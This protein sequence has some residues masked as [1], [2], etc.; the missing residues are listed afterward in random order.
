MAIVGCTACCGCCCFA[1]NP[2]TSTKAAG[3]HATVQPAQRPD[4]E[5]YGA[6]EPLPNYKSSSGL[7]EVEPVTGPDE[8]PPSYPEAVRLGSHAKP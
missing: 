2:A 3:T 1:P 7:E 6:P 8:E 4:L 5:E